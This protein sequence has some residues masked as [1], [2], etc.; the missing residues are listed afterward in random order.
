MEDLLDDAVLEDTSEPPKVAINRK[1]TYNALNSDLLKQGAF[2]SL[3][4]IDL[5]IL[6]RYLLN[7]R[8]LVEPDEVW[9]WDQ[10]FTEVSGD[11][12]AEKPKSA[13]GGNAVG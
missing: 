10:L 1:A 12:H 6:A 13:D 8:D 2:A 4:D 11:I 5:L 3:D 7:E 9:T